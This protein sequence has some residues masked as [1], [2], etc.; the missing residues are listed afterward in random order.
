MKC[1]TCGDDQFKLRAE[2]SRLHEENERLVLGLA[3]MQRMCDG[4][5]KENDRLREENE[6]LK[7]E[8]FAHVQKTSAL[9]TKLRKGSSDAIIALREENEAL[10]DTLRCTTRNCDACIENIN[11]LR[12]ENTALRDRLERAKGLL[13]A[14]PLFRLKKISAT[15]VEQFLAEQDTP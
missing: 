3:R 4:E 5:L 10:K 11:P 8:H 15:I 6:G 12:K 14:I 13:R 9:I 7:A 1:I 2:L